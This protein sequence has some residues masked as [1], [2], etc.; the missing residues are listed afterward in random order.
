MRITLQQIQK[1]SETGRYELSVG[2]NDEPV[3][4]Y[5]AFCDTSHPRI[6]ICETDHELFFILSEWSIHRY[7]N[8]TIYQMELQCI[9]VNQYHLYQSSWE[10][11]PLA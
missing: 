4:H 7:G 10:R 3:K 11:R 5:S 9:K 2:V 6:S 1:S 8:C